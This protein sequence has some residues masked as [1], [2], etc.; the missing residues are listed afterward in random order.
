GARSPAAGHEVGHRQRRGPHPRPDPGRQPGPPSR[1][2]HRDQRDRGRRRGAVRSEERR[3]S[4]VTSTR[5]DGRVVAIYGPVVDVE[6]PPDELPEINWALELT[7]DVEGRSDM[8]VA[9][10]A[11]HIGTSRVRAVAMKPTD[12]LQRGTS[13]TN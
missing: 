3:M 13:V 9:E 1:D 4:T 7:R 5:A 12:G 11:Q 10:V 2:H 6:F 8:I